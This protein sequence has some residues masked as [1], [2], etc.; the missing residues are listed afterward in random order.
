MKS[1]QSTN[2][3]LS[4]LLDESQVP[5]PDP[6]IGAKPIDV[7]PEPELERPKDPGAPAL[8]IDSPESKVE[9]SEK[10]AKDFLNKFKVTSDLILERLSADREEQQQILN[11]LKNVVFNDP[12]CKGVYVEALANIIRAKSDSN[13]NTTKLL[14]SIARMLAAGKDHMI[15]GNA[16]PISTEDLRKLLAQPRFKDEE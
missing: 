11:H 10:Y 14:D 13:T 9:E 6:E 15:G 2:D 16:G 3:E 1:D 12:D 4:K 8:P 7:I 5:F